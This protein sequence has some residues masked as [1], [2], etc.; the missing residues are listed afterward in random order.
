MKAP[1]I[2]LLSFVTSIGYYEKETDLKNCAQPNKVTIIQS[3]YL[4]VHGVQ[5][6]KYCPD[7]KQTRDIVRKSHTAATRHQGDKQSKAT[8]S[9]SLSLS[10]SLFPIKMIAKLEWTSINAQQNIEQLQNSTMRVTI[11]IVS[12]TTEPRL[13]T[14][15]NQSLDSGL[16][17]S[18]KNRHSYKSGG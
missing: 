11:K 8:S 10:L 4:H 13:I 15:S 16:V 9:L 14:D 2:A 5:N 18:L 3:L 6:E 12:T 1:N 17:A 7:L